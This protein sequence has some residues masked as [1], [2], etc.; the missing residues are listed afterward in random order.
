VRGDEVRV[1]HEVFAGDR[2]AIRR[3]AVAVALNGLLEP[4]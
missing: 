1:R 4:G 2:D 3:K